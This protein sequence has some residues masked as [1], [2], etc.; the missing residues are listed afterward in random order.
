ME[1]IILTKELL[2][3]GTNH[4]SGS[5]TV[6]QCEILGIPFLNNKKHKQALIGKEISKEL[7]DKFCSEKLTLGKKVARK[8]RLQKLKFDALKK[9]KYVKDF[10]ELLKSSQNDDLLVSNLRK[11]KYEDFLKTRYWR[12]VRAY[13]IEQSGRKCSVCGEIKYLNVHH[14]SYEH[15]G[16]EIFH[17]EDLVVLCEKCHSKAHN[18]S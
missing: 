5:L 10:E 9:D 6:K 17:L 15:H 1:T 12:T 11:M 18:L 2:R 7:Y 8:K 3:A 13:V 16:S 14:K 4:G